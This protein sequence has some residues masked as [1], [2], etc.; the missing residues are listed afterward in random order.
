M[1][2]SFRSVKL[3]VM[4]HVRKAASIYFTLIELLVRTTC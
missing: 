3:P 2:K 4:N 1:Q